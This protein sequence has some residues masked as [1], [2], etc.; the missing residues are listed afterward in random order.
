MSERGVPHERDV[1]TTREGGRAL[2]AMFVAWRGRRGGTSVM[3]I[4]G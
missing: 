4:E 3:W 1:E 2:R